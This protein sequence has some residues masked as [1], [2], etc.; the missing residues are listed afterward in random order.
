MKAW[1]VGDT[2]GPG[3]LTLAERPDPTCGATDVVVA[4]EAVSLNFRDLLVTKG[5]HNP[6]GPPRGEGPRSSAAGLSL[7]PPP[8]PSPRPR[9][10]D[11]RPRLA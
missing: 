11:V 6:G 2:P 1:V 10:I 4:V 3:G 9:D 5:A 7:R 8:G